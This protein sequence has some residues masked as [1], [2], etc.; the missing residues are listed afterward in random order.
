VCT[1]CSDLATCWRSGGSTGWGVA[2][3]MIELMGELEVERIGFESVTES[4]DTVTPGGKLVFY[5]A[6]AGDS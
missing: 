5:V 2:T 1:I 6:A 4:I 3:H